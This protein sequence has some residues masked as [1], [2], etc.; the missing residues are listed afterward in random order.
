MDTNV[1]VII[2]DDEITKNKLQSI[3]ESFGGQARFY[4]NES[5]F[6]STY[7]YPST[8]LS[9]ECLIT[10]FKN[11]DEQ[12]IEKLYSLKNHGQIMP[13]IV[14]SDKPSVEFCRQSFKMGAFEF[15][16][17]PLKNA[18]ILEAI[19]SAAEI[20]QVSSERYQLF[21]TLSNKFKKL[22]NRE[23]E[24]MTMILE[25]NTS[26]EAA[27]KLSLS[28]RTVEVHRSNIYTKLKIKSLPQLVNEYSYI[29][30]YTGNA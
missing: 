21:L 27:E 23:K 8:N 4:D 25:G 11:D 17:L 2:K 7:T 26:K 18:D 16:A 24:V 13:I 29:T 12:K 19:N 3:I 6:L 28:P 20:Y 10:Y 9:K 22:S 15:F 14:V 1:H 5:L 30:N